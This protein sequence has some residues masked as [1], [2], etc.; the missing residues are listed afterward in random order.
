MT[1]KIFI[2]KRL[3]VATSTSVSGH[4]MSVISYY[5]DK[6]TWRK[7][8]A[9]DQAAQSGVSEEISNDIV[10]GFSINDSLNQNHDI[11]T[12]ETKGLHINDPRGFSVSV[13]DSNVSS[14]ARFCDIVNQKIQG[15]MVYAW[16]NGKFILLPVASSFYTEAAQYSQT[17]L[18]KIKGQ[19]LIPGATYTT[20]QNLSFIYLG[21][22]P[23]YYY[24]DAKWNY[25]AFGPRKMSLLYIF[26]QENGIHFHFLP[27]KTLDFLFALKDGNEHP[28]HAFYV[29]E[30][31]SSLGSKKI[32][33]FVVSPFS[34][35]SQ[36]QI[37][38]V[39]NLFTDQDGVEKV[40]LISRLYYNYPT[41][42]INLLTGEI[43]SIDTKKSVLKGILST[44]ISDFYSIQLNKAFTL[45]SLHAILE[46]GQKIEVN[47]L[48]HLNPSRKI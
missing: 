33:S 43:E 3:K 44:T 47:E 7:T 30:F 16:I 1:Q 32:D 11:W 26:V 38:H 37:D 25:V 15:K 27:K 22:F 14:I 2:P 36:S 29:K 4:K 24:N 31:N 42:C 17:L 19:H 41:Y 5:D 10:E 39:W 28:K 18:T 48:K 20:K 45:V 40:Q 23:Y 9:W 21:R 46:N 35:N 13:N 6:N 34:F 12:E 8:V